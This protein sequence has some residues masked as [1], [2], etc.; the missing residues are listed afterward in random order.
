[1]FRKITVS[2]NNYKDILKRIQKTTNGWRM[3]E[4]YQVFRGDLRHE[5]RQYKR[6]SIGIDKNAY[7]NKRSNTY[8]IKYKIYKN[9]SFIKTTE[10]W[11][12]IEHDNDS[13]SYHGEMYN[14]MHPLIHM[15]KDTWSAN[16][17]SVGDRIMFLPFGI[18]ITYTDD[19]FTHTNPDKPLAVY[20]QTFIP[21]FFGGKIH[22][23]DDEELKRT[24]EEEEE[25]KWWDDEFR[26]DE[27]YFYD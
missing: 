25:A 2:E 5:E 14:N 22:D 13:D 11:L 15:N 21:D 9:N 17:I 26:R 23:L 6:F 7:Y 24:K 16:V 27:E 3:L 1:M 12:K 18:F 20:R 4:R 10:H 8:E 19:S